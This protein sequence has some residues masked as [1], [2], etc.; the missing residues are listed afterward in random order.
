VAAFP[1][2]VDYSAILS[3]PLTFTI[4]QSA[5]ALALASSG[6]SAVCGQPVSFIATVGAVAGTPS[7]TVTFS[8]GTTRLATVP[9]DGSSMAT[10]TTSALSLGSHPITTT[11]SGDADFLGVQSAPYSESVAQTST[12]VVVVPNSVF[13]KKKKL[14][15][16]RL[17]AEIKPLAPGGAYRPAR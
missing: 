13:N 14:I 4:G 10:F 12:E 1:G 17:T 3:T 5:A 6:R 11:Y 8:N 7:G 15:S 2:N 9:L 16:V